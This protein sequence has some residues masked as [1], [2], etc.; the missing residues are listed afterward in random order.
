MNSNEQTIDF[1]YDDSFGSYSDNH[2]SMNKKLIERNNHEPNCCFC[3]K[4][5]CLFFVIY[6]WDRSLFNLD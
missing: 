2:Y 6:F 1:T 5:C 3:C 4:G